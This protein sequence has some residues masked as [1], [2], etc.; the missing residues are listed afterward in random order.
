M[1]INVYLSAALYLLK[2]NCFWTVLHP[3]CKN[4]GIVNK[5]TVSDD[6]T[7][8]DFCLGKYLLILLERGGEGPEQECKRSNHFTILIILSQCQGLKVSAISTRP[9]ASSLPCLASHQNPFFSTSPNPTMA[10]AKIMTSLDG[11]PLPGKLKQKR[12]LI[13]CFIFM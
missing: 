5:L 11:C 4:V 6:L 10:L 2:W 3:Y 9:G 1:K 12:D 7:H 13:L 8:F